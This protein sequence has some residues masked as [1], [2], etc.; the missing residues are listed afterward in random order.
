[1]AMVTM[2]T[3]TD[4]SDA[5]PLLSDPSALRRQAAADGYVFIRGL[6]DGG[7]LQEVAAAVRAIT[8]DLG[9]TDAA[10]RCPPGAPVACEGGPGWRAFYDRVQSLRCFHALPHAPALAAVMALLLDGPVLVHP[11]N[12]LRFVP[13]GSSRQTTPPHQDH[14]YIGGT[15][16]TWTVWI[17]LGDCP[18]EMGGLAVLPGSHRYGRLAVQAAEGTG[19]HGI[20]LGDCTGSWRSGPFACGDVLLLHSHTVHQGVDNRSAAQPRV[21]IDC[22][23][24]RRDAALAAASLQPHQGWLDWETIYAGWSP[25]DPLRYYWRD[26]DLQLEDA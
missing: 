5:A 3:T 12:I 17:P 24:Q 8:M 15:P 6:V 1:M 4:F 7:A 26:W 23:F 10:G 9:W 11:R 19:G 18:L 22:R 2:S 14:F 16:E 20:A 13:P 21:S 25:Q